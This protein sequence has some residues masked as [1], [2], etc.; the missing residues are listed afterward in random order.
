MNNFKLRNIPE[1]DVS[2]YLGS[3]EYILYGF[4]YK[5]GIGRNK[6]VSRKYFQ[7]KASEITDYDQLIELCQYYNLTGDNVLI[8]IQKIEDGKR[9]I[10]DNC[11]IYVP[12]ID[13]GYIE[14]DEDYKSNIRED[15]NLV[16]ELTEKIRKQDEKIYKLELQNEYQQKII[17]HYQN[18]FDIVDD[19]NET[20]TGKQLVDT[21]LNLLNTLMTGG[22]EN[23]NKTNNENVSNNIEE[24]TEEDGFN[25]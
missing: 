19:E 24:Y 5:R 1:T 2:D 23:S 9:T 22:F 16:L 25:F 15:S 12:P 10:I 11:E 14:D 8:K 20:D 6:P 13:G 18:N 3:D 21:S 17:D 4:F 7:I